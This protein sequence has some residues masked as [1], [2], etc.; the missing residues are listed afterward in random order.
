M[1]WNYVTAWYWPP[2]HSINKLKLVVGQGDSG[3]VYVFENVPH[4]QRRPE[5]RAV[6]QG[7]FGS[8]RVDV[9]AGADTVTDFTAC[10]DFSG[11]DYW[12]YAVAYNGLGAGN[13]ASLNDTPVHRLRPHLGR[14]RERRQRSPPDPGIG[15]GAYRLFLCSPGAGQVAQ[16][17]RR[18]GVTTRWLTR[19]RGTLMTGGRTR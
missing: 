13:L 3:F 7:W 5:G 9:R 18:S 2:K 14:L 16:D 12:L 19:E 10:R 15:S 11:D 17:R 4:Q 1:T 6:Q 8:R